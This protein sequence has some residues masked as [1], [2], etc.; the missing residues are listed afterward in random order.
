[1]ARFTEKPDRFS[2]DL[3]LGK[4]LDPNGFINLNGT[5]PGIRGEVRKY[6]S[7]SALRQLAARHR[8][9][10]LSPTVDL[11]EAKRTIMRLENQLRNANERAAE[12]ELRVETYVTGF[13]QMLH[14]EPPKRQGRPP[15]KADE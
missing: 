15:K 13:K 10:G 9:I 12:L 8:E 2:K 11:D 3:I 4:R 6:L 7:I 14:R 1:M 5:I